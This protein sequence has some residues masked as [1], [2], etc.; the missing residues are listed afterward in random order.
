MKPVLLIVDDDPQ[1]L[2]AVGI[3]LRHKYGDHFRVLKADSGATALDILKQLKLRNE[4]PALFLVD[5]RMPHMTGEFLEQA[6]KIYPDAKRVLLTAYAD[7][8]AAIGSINN[9]RIDFYL[10]KP[11]ILLNRIYSRSLMIYLMIGWLHLDLHLKEFVL[12]VYYG[13]PNR[14]KQGYF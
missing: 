8:D 5:Q 3:D 7:T 10:M 11:W 1:V 6:M 9:A 14:M 13:H 12:L 4:P 2:Q